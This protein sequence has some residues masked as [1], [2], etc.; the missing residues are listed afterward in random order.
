MNGA[1]NSRAIELEE[2]RLREANE[3]EVSYLVHERH[4]AF[5]DVF[6]GRRP[7]RMI[8]LSAGT[9]LVAEAIRA[10]GDVE[11]VCNELSP[12][13]RQ[14]LAAKGFTATAVDLDDPSRDYAFE[15]GAFDAVVCLATI[16]HLINIDHFVMQVKRMLDDRG[17]LYLSAPNYAG[18]PYLLPFL[19]SG[20]TFHDP[21]KRQ[22]RYEFYAHVRYFTY[23]T[24]RE[25]VESFGFCLDSVY[26]L[27]PKS[28][29]K[30]TEL[31]RRSPSRAALLRAGMRCMYG[32]FSP[33]WAAEPIL[34]FRKGPGRE[35]RP[36]KVVL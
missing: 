3:Q 19:L 26:L 12:G 33:R 34:C 25:Y 20:R 32:L 13:C 11:L 5:P 4:R 22:S 27:T 24:L 16:E 30:F 17:L 28:S 8:D 7:R 1:I 29:T 10:A 23:R 36:R 31:R 2:N 21:L 14:E 6:E 9:G 15:D 18:L 35:T